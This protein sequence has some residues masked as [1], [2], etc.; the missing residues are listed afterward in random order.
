MS[1]ETDG[2]SEAI[3]LW[4]NNTLPGI[5]KVNGEPIEEAVCFRCEYTENAAYLLDRLLF[6][7][8]E[9]RFEIP[10]DAQTELHRIIY[11]CIRTKDLYFPRLAHLADA[12]GRVQEV[13]KVLSIGCGM[14]FQEAFL[15]GRFPQIQVLATDFLET[16]KT[17]PFNNLTFSRKDILEW[18]E[19]GDYDFVFSIETLEHIEDYRRAF[20]NMAVKVKPGKYLYV[21]VPFANKSEQQNEALKKQELE[22]YGH[23]LPGFSYEDLETLFGENGFEVL[24]SSNMF[25]NFL[26]NILNRV[27]GK[28]SGASIEVALR[29]FGEL[30]LMDTRERRVDSRNTS[31]GIRMLGKKL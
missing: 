21:S 18:D 1:I 22:T 23:F 27:L 13:S 4:S 8:P 16:W 6:R 30:F 3:G 15:A 25:D 17:Y 5:C 14:A 10:A 12:F 19:E 26:V 29:E 31:V 11:Y 7:N 20:R 9:D 24:H 28:I 2:K